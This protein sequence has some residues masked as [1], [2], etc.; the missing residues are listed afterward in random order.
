MYESC[1]TPKEFGRIAAQTAKQIMVQRIRE[2]ERGMIYD[3]FS[4]KEN[5][6]VNAVVQRVERNNVFVQM[7]KT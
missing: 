1:V 6:F 3:E 5:E 2:A 4:Q 7:G